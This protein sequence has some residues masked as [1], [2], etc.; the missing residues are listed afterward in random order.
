MKISK[1][2]KIAVGFALFLSGKSLLGPRDFAAVKTIATVVEVTL[3][4][5]FGPWEVKLPC[6]NSSEQT[7]K[8]ALTN[9]NRLIS[10]LQCC[11]TNKA[12]KIR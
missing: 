3:W 4:G 11:K 6:Y 10:N 12:D 1:S 8:T 2:F 5:H 9:P 7:F